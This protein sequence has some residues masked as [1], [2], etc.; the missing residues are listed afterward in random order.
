MPLLS[1]NSLNRWT[2]FRPDGEDVFCRILIPI[3]NHTTAKTRPLPYSK[4]RDTFRAAARAARRTQ[5][6]SKLFIHFCE[7]TPVP[8]GFISEHVAECGPPGIEDRFRHSC[9]RQPGCV[10]VTDDYSFEPANQTSRMLMQV[11]HPTVGNF[12]VDRCRALSL[13][14]PLGCRQLSC[15]LSRV[16]RVAYKGPI[17]EGG[18]RFQTKI[19]ADLTGSCRLRHINFTQYVYV[20][21]PASIPGKRAALDGSGYGPGHP[22]FVGPLAINNRVPNNFYS[23]GAERHP[24]QGVAVASPFWATPFRGAGD[25]KCPTDFSYRIAACVEEWRNARTEVVEIVP[26]RPLSAPLHGVALNLATVVPN[27][28]NST[29][30]SRKV[31]SGRGVFNPIAIRQKHAG[32]IAFLA[33]A[34]KEPS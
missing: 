10:D 23:I 3:V 9:F 22:Y 12:G 30:M 6:G 19:N 32:N 29:R 28:I 16:A 21:T 17:A 31:F 25:V 14:C 34:H 33:S 7:L 27:V 26:S 20:P 18:Q 15:V 4:L 2:A 5:L 8:N 13:S 1:S 11:V 24:P